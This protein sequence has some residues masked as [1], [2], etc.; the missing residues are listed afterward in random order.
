MS[1]RTDYLPSNDK[2][3]LIWIKSIVAYANLNFERWRIGKPSDELIALIDDFEAK[4]QKM[5][6]PNHGSVDTREKNDARH[7]LEK[8]A[9]GFVQGYIA[10]NPM[11]TN[12]DKESMG[13]PI[14]DTTPTQVSI[15]I[16]QAVVSVEYLGGQV[17]QLYISHVNSTPFDDKANYGCKIYYDVFADSDTQPTSGENLT[18]HTFTRRKKEVIRFTPSDVK[19]TAYFCIRYENSK[20]KS[21]PWGPMVSA[22]IP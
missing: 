20:G 17:L 11:V 21:G 4:L 6:D 12:V 9:R 10:K 1:K 15:P 14:Y 16:G 22:I 13:L 19:K 7:T 8:N 3:F 2:A 18:R 5:D